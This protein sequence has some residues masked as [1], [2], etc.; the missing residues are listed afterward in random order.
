MKNKIIPLDEYAGSKNPPKEERI[1]HMMNWKQKKLAKKR[2]E[3]DTKGWGSDKTAWDSP[4]NL[5][6]RQSIHQEKKNNNDNFKNYLITES[7]DRIKFTNK[8]G[9]YDEYIWCKGRTKPFFLSK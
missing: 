6:W 9:Q 3:L 2:G 5:P 4:D 1:M 7:P 8:N